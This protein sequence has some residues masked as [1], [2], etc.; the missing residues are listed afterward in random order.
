[1]FAAIVLTI[2]RLNL[3]KQQERAKKKKLDVVT[4]NTTEE[5]MA[6]VAGA[7]SGS[8]IRQIHMRTATHGKRS[9]GAAVRALIMYH[10]IPVLTR[11]EVARV[12]RTHELK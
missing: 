5:W 4:A 10:L 12:S 1:V 3:P 6:T 7:S 2:P 9:L 8:Q 11:S